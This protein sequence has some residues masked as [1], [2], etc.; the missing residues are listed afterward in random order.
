[1]EQTLHEIST[2]QSPFQHLDRIHSVMGSLELCWI[3]GAPKAQE[4]N[5]SVISVLGSI[6]TEYRYLEIVLL[7]RKLYT[8]F[9]S[10]SY[11]VDRSSILEITVD[12]SKI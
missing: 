3:Q 6:V 8:S 9:F 1:M 4:M 7:R 5:R 11:K 2:V 10:A 12:L